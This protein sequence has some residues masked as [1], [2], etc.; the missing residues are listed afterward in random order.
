ML[1]CTTWN[2]F[3]DEKRLVFYVIGL[4]HHALQPHIAMT[5][6]SLKAEKHWNVSYYVGDNN[7]G[8]FLV[9]IW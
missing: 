9:I 7:V 5:A 3:Y 1:F 4:L 2:H 6:S 8:V